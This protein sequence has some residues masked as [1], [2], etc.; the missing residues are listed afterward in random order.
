[1][2]LPGIDMGFKKA[3]EV[4]MNKDGTVYYATFARPWTGPRTGTVYEAG[5]RHSFKHK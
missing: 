3:H 5:K 4:M 1:M 2:Q